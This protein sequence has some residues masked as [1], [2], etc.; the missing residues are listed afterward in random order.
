M[1]RRLQTILICSALL[2]APTE[3]FTSSFNNPT[4]RSTSIRPFSST[5]LRAKKG[6]NKK[7]KTDQ[8]QKSGFAWA[9]G[10]TLKP[11]EAQGLRELATNALASFEGRKA[12]ETLAP[13]VS[14]GSN[15]PPKALW[16]T[17]EI[18]LVIM[19]DDGQLLYANMA[20]LETVNLKADE[21]E[22]L[23]PAASGATQASR[24]GEE[25]QQ[26]TEAAVV[27]DL[28]AE[29]KGD[30]KYE[31]GYSKKVIK[32]SSNDSYDEDIK[33]IE[34]QRWVLEKSALVGG[35]FTTTNLGVAYAWKEWLVGESLLRS[36]GGKEKLFANV[37]ELEAA[38]EKQAAFIR[39]LKEDQGFGNKDLEV[40]EAVQKLVQLKDQ[41]AAAKT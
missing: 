7:G 4:A 39:E 3:A 9:A 36:P 30:K 25:E 20:A 16:N 10:F 5:R 34:A 26:P 35:K 13:E 22:K 31:S 17:K 37:E 28:P 12:G 21:F 41:I 24:D 2:L 40:V 18:A 15:D 33:I 38:L 1:T 14:V 23:C 32:S 29:M 27:L 11:F 19:G 6:K 8:N